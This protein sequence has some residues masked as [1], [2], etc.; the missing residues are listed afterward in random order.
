MNL[1]YKAIKIL[2]SASSRYNR[3]F[4]FEEKD[5]KGYVKGKYGFYDKHGKL[6]VI[7]YE[8]HPKHGFHAERAQSHL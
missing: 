4:R 7:K 3:L 1:Y 6:Q 2:Y 5:G 8:A